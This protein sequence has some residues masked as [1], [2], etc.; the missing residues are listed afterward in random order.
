V[1]QD[2][3]VVRPNGI[4]TTALASAAP[5]GSLRRELGVPDGA[6]L[7]LALGRM[8]FKKGLQTLIASVARLPGVHLVV[9]GP[10]D[11]DGTLAGL[12]ALREQLAVHDR[13]HLRGAG[14]WG[15]DRARAF[16]DADVLCLYSL[17]E[18]F[19]AAAVEAAYCGVATI[20]SD[21]CG[22]AEWLDDGTCVVPIDRPELLVTALRR[23]TG[24]P[25]ERAR[26]AAAGRAAAATLAWPELARRQA[27]IYAS[28]VR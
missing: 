9:A 21:Q 11:G 17:T 4:V 2:R 5:R 20:V 25:A 24:D 16:A 22:A 6:P 26:I 27:G 13:V 7:V 28:I 10:D 23:L 8:A 19:G 1:A 15:E 18:N 3:I 12:M 14:L